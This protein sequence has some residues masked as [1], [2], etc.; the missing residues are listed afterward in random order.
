MGIFLAV[1]AFQP[2]TPENLASAIVGVA[3]SFGVPAAV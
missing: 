2:V 3:S 1:S